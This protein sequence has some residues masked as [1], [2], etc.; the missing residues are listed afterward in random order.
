MRAAIAFALLLALPAVARAQD[1]AD[2]TP[3]AAKGPPADLPPAPNGIAGE[4]TPSKGFD[5]VKT[6]WGSLNI[7]G[8][9][10]FR[11]VNQLG[12]TTFVDHLGRERVVKERNDLNWHRTMIWL[13]GFALTPRLA[14]VFTVWSLPTTQ[15]T[16]AFGNLQYRFSDALNLGVGIGPSLT[17][18]SMQG[19]HPFW[20]SS[21]RQ[22]GE[23]FFRGGFSSGIWLRG[24]P[25]PRFQ[26]W[27]SVNTNLSQLGVTA[28]NDSRAL[29]YSASV[30]WLPTTGEFGQ[31]G[32]LADFEQHD[33]LATRFG[34]SGGHAREN[35]AAELGQESPNATQIRLSDGVLAFETGALAPGV[36][37]IDLDYDELAF[38]VGLKWKGISFQGEY[39]LRR[40]SQFHATG[41]L[42]Q[43]AIL[44]HGFFVQ[45]MAMVV[46]R[47]VGLYASGTVIR[48]E[49]HRNPWEVSGGM[50]VFPMESRSWRL[51]LHLIHVDRSPTGSVFGFYTA[52]QTGNTISLGTDILL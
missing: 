16:L 21:D 45:G 46:P 22:M 30:A 31:R 13:S 49:F 23:E 10:L 33:R 4:L 1:E 27:A 19:S 3:P 15:Q 35:R 6:E 2:P 5:L 18:R 7:S 17:N 40:L 37:V 47:V 41:P 24:E 28:V 9:G 8:Y 20:A 34:M 39:F 25:L 42:P 11:Y 14:Y 50:S 51:N 38:D 32:G 12:N 26:Y 43:D 44:D 52:G 48:D 36:T 29:A